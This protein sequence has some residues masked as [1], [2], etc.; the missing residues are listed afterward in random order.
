MLNTI[1]FEGTGFAELPS[2]DM[3]KDGSLFF[4]F[5]TY[6]KD[7]LMLL[8]KGVNPSV[9]I[10]FMIYHFAGSFVVFKLL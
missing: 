10:F 4:S 8:A 5:I 2:Y 9:S 3:G 7:G 6:H 1:G